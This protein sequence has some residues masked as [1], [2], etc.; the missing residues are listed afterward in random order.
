MQAQIQQ[1]ETMLEAPGAAGGLAKALM[2]DPLR[3]RDFLGSFSQRLEGQRPFSVKSRTV[4][5]ISPDG[6]NLLSARAGIKPPGDLEFCKILTKE[7]GVVA[8][9]VNGD[10]FE[11]HY[12]G[13]YAIAAA[14]AT[15]IRSD[16][17]ASVT[18]SVLLLQ[19]LFIL[20][21]RSP[22]KLFAL[23]F[24]PIAL[25]LLLGF[26]G[27]SLAQKGLSP[28]TAVL[29]G[30]LAGMAIDYAIQYLSMY[31]SQ[32]D[33]GQTACDAAA[34]SAVSITPAAF[35]AWATSVVGFLAIGTSHV[36]ALRDFALLGTLGLTGA[37]LA[38]M[39][40]MPLLLM[41]TD[42]RNR[43]RRPVRHFDSA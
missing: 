38:K 8:N 35:A 22:F 18:G 34:A 19:L 16:M 26:G 17:I 28:M 33:I 9:R 41:L 24:G 6:R 14:S 7:V 11:L 23:S 3:L 29:G 2:R 27:Y 15:A 30:V 39:A 36:N 42:R 4:P 40:L 13:S 5:F 37:F 43:A 10:G 31:E 12:A 20:A 21:Y 1:D 32:R 25:G